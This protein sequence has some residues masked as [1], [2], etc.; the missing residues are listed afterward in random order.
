MNK[1]ELLKNI[2]GMLKKHEG[3]LNSNPEV[4][5]T[6]QDR[7]LK[8]ID[9]EDWEGEEPQED[10]GDYYGDGYGDDLFDSVPDEDQEERFEDD[11]YGDD[12][13]ARWLADN[14]RE[15][16]SDMG[17][18]DS[19]DEAQ[20][21]EGIEAGGEAPV[22]QPVEAKPKRSSR[23]TDWK[24]KDKYEDHHQSAIEKLMND[25]YSHREAERI[26]GAHE[27]PTDF[28]SAL[29][30]TVNP[31]EPSPK[32]LEQMKAL[33]HEWLRNANRTGDASAD[34]SMNPQKYSSGK[35]I[36]AHEDAHGNFHDAYQEF[37]G[38]DELKGLRGRARHQAIK[39]WKNN[40]HEQNPEYKDK[41]AS[42][43]GV[44]KEYE[45]ANQARKQRRDE[46]TQAILEAGMAHGGDV[47]GYSSEAAGGV[48]QNMST[49]HAAQM[50][51]GEKGESGYSANIQKD[52]A[53]VFAERNQ[54][55]V[56]HLKGKLEGKLDEGQQK[57]MAAV[58]SFKNK[59][60]K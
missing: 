20:N 27:A 44:G 52:P 36:A 10:E 12:D 1:E 30:H 48:D 41:A 56:K 35:A 17:Y 54:D 45:S 47:G 32:M 11:E 26:A 9:Y 31:S 53:A 58:D 25:G 14:D 4:F 19:V 37:L 38:S 33:S 18:D 13:A 49:Q 39:E 6:I 29:K 57:R 42:V 28:Y 40:F 2:S 34:A 3:Y 46:G 43:A 24:A 55:Y 5:Y 60:S 21:D 16:E 23:Y 50:V 51:G 15:P 59:G 22:E 7:L 8:A